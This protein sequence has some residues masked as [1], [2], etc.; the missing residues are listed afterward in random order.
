M[1][2]KIL[3]TIIFII[4]NTTIC[5]ANDEPDSWAQ[6]H[7]LEAMQKN[8][9]PNDLKNGYKDII[10]R[11]DFCVLLIHN[12]SLYFESDIE[13]VM[14]YFG[15]KKV[16]T[17]F[18]D[19]SDKNIDAAYSMGI[20]SGPN[21]M[22]FRP[23][24]KITRQESA[25]MI[26]KMIYFL[27]FTDLDNAKYIKFDDE[28]DISPWAYNDVFYVARNNIM[29]GD[30]RGNFLP[31]AVFTR[32]QAFITFL[33]LYN[34]IEQFKTIKT[35]TV[36]LNGKHIKLDLHVN[37]VF[38]NFG[39]PTHKYQIDDSSYWCVYYTDYTDLIFVGIKNNVVSAIATNSKSFLRDNTDFTSTFGILNT[40]E[41]YILDSNVVE[42]VYIYKPSFNFNHSNT[43]V[44]SLELFHFTNAFRVKNN[45]NPLKIEPKLVESAKRHSEDM[46][47]NNYF[48]H[49]SLDGRNLRDRIFEV[50]YSFRNVGENIAQGYDNG[51]RAFEGLINSKGH[52]DNILGNYNE[53]GT[54]M[55]ISTAKEKYYTQ[56]FGTKLVK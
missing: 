4:L 33:N 52:R 14:D 24:D 17:N 47:K 45:L 18:K 7:V 1:C 23:N 21:D 30:G 51:F 22:Y 15:V 27:K 56:N 35:N 38:K 53:V 5:Y 36:K 13:V 25:V 26:S 6:K 49:D 42:G 20:I 43:T 48:S 39:E 8:I 44:L 41:I 2:K 9:I 31:L 3:C 40:T 19:I 50:S 28:K 55:A 54:Y 16:K 29:N 46:A 34:I 11:K 32:Q 10:T 37:E 12:I